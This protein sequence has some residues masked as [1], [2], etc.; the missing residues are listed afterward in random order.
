[1]HEPSEL[2]LKR[3]FGFTLF[4]HVRGQER[5]SVITTV[6]YVTNADQEKCQ[7]NNLTKFNA[8]NKHFKKGVALQP[9]CFGISFTNNM[10]NNAKKHVK[11]IFPKHILASKY[12]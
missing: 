8:E 1:M 10:M 3:L 6:H 12:M 4:R 11:R 5:R 7:N 9:I 2:H